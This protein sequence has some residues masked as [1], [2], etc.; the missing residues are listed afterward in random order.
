MVIPNLS[1]EETSQNYL[2]QLVLEH[3]FN[4]KDI[5]R[6]L[7]QRMP[8]LDRDDYESE[9]KHLITIAVKNVL[10]I[11]DGRMIHLLRKYQDAMVYIVT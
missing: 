3:Y 2:L 7:K 8:I 4:I 10:A 9:I 6:M 1:A 11:R 5:S